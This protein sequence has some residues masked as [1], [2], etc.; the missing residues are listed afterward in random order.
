MCHWHTHRFTG[1]IQYIK[2]ESKGTLP[3][4]SVAPVR[5]RCKQVTRT[6]EVMRFCKGVGIAGSFQIN[7]PSKVHAKL[8]SSFN[9]DFRLFTQEQ[10]RICKNLPLLF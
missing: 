5:V 6:R 1:V 7:V 4:Y 10:I 8:A 3:V 9:I 2:E